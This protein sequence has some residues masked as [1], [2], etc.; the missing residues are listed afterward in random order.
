M[1]NM[2]FDWNIITVFSLLGIMTI[3]CFGLGY[4]DVFFLSGS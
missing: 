4:E 1:T 2:S 3:I